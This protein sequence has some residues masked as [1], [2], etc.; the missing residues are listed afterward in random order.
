MTEFFDFLETGE[1]YILRVPGLE[2]PLTLPSVWLL[3]EEQDTQIASLNLIGKIKWNQ[4]LGRLIAQCIRQTLP[5]LEGI[6]FITVVEKALQLAQVVASELGVK[7]IAIAYN[8]VKPHMEAL[9]RP[10]IQVGADSVTSGMK[11][12]A[13][14]ER[15]INL[16]VT[17]AT[18][19]LVIV[20]DVVTTGGTIFGLI[21]LLDQLARLKKLQRPFPIHGIFCVAEEGTRKRIL[22]APVYPLA[23]LPDPVVR[24]PGTLKQKPFQERLWDKP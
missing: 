21:D 6:C 22:P 14:Y 10:V 15:D 19:G 11:F 24:R 8:R 5:S 3:G 4:D 2:Y 20:D 1:H 9:R 17:A 23:R 18:R 12:L 13:F 7:D 16:L